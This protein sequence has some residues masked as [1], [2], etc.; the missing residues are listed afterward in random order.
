MF[1]ERTNLAQQVTAELKALLR[2]ETLPDT[3]PRNIG[4]RGS[5]HGKPALVTIRGRKAR[6]VICRL[7]KEI[8][9]R[10]ATRTRNR[11]AESLTTRP[12]EHRE[13]AGRARRDVDKTANISMDIYVLD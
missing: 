7:A 8:M 3:I 11:R 4:W 13:D 1:D 12:R 6:R 9:K 10:Q 2:G 5:Q